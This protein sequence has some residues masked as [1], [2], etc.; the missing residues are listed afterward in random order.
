M[1]KCQQRNGAVK[2]VL[3]DFE[4]IGKGMVGEHI[5][6]HAPYGY[7]K[8]PEPDGVSWA[9]CQLYVLSHL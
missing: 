1:C 3:F 6:S 5:G 9:Y 4:N 2:S 8:N 7:R